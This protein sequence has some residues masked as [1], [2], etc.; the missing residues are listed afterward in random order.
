MDFFE[1]LRREADRLG[2]DRFGVVGAEAPPDYGRY[3]DWVARGFAAELRYMVE[4]TRAK[5][6]G[7]LS[8]VL[9]GVRSVIVGGFSYAPNSPPP[10]TDAKWARYGWGR[11]YHE[12]VKEKLDALVAWMRA[13]APEPFEARTYVDTGPI[14][15]RSLAERAGIGWIGKNTCVI[16]RDLGSYLYL[17]EV[18]TTLAL[19]LSAQARNHCGTCT[20]CI[21]ACPTQA[22]EAPYRLNAQK[23][24]SYQTLENRTQD[25]PPSIAERLEGWVAGCDICQ[26]VCPWNRDAPPTRHPDFEP[27]QHAFVTRDEIARMDAA[28]F[29]EKFGGTSFERTGLLKLQRTVRQGTKIP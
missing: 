29:A 3:L 25:I 1:E 4:E 19:P 10:P 7:D 21:D 27:R 11:D 22:I 6:R 12:V 20:K 17:G 28:Q 13:N 18:L 5:K 16:D 8:L 26:E 2:F 14:L 15:E 23:C 9:P 24:I